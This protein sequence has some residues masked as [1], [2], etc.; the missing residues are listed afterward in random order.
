MIDARHCLGDRF[1]YDGA[2]QYTPPVGF[3]LEDLLVVAELRKAHGGI[4]IGDLV[5]T[6]GAEEIG[7]DATVLPYSV[8]ALP[9]ETLLWPPGPIVLTVT[10]SYGDQCITSRPISI[11]THLRGE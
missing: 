4:K 6:K 7:S 1:Q 9:A 3:V 5:V 2:L 10:V 8:T 11:R